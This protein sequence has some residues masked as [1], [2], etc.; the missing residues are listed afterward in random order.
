MIDELSELCVSADSTIRQVIAC[1]EKNTAKIALVVNEDTQLLNT[2]TD[3]DVRRAMLAGT[4][5]D[6]P[7][8]LLQERKLASSKYKQ[9]VTAPLGTDT[10]ELLQLMRERDV[11]QVP[12]VDEKQSVVG[13]VT[14]RELIADDTLPIQA[15]VMAG[16]SGTRLRPLTENLPKPMVPVGGRPMLERIIEQLRDAGVS[17]VM[18]TTH[19]KSELIS[20]HFG[21]GHGFGVNISYVEEDKP[22]GTAGGLS[23]LEPSDDPILVINGDILTRIDFRAMLDFH[24]EH[25]A[26]MSVAVRRHETQIPYGVIET[27]DEKITQVLEKPIV[28]HFIN[29][30]IYL[31]NPAVFK[32]IPENDSYDMPELIN[33]LINDGRTVISFPVREYWLDIGQHKDYMRAEEDVR[34]GKV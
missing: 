25:K 32:L 4:D 29:A 21:D 6:E 15:V 20:S 23:Q 2:V 9:A 10:D 1:I 31:L 3:G 33:R 26:E 5:L 13:L 18:V 12:L 30:G 7:V 14:L 34:K 19:Y 24:V 11:R 27:E 16:G 22:M 28:N 8:K 17:R